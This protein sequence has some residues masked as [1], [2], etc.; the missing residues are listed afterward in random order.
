MD[1]LGHPESRTS[2]SDTAVEEDMEMVA[3]EEILM[4]PQK[5]AHAIDRDSDSSDDEDDAG[6]GLLVSGSRRRPGHAHT[7]SLSL[8]RGI[9]I[10]QQVKNIVIEVSGRPTTRPP[11]YLTPNRLHLHYCSQYWA[12][13]SLES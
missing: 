9:D 13:C 6:R 1:K 2:S 5:A 10:W 3:F 12:S 11:Q 8:S 4:T 7:R